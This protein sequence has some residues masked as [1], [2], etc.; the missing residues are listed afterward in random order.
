MHS[1]IQDIRYGL[2]QLRKSPAFT[3]IA[4]LIIATG[5]A[6]NV[7]VFAFRDALFLQSMP[8]QNASGLVRIRTSEN[9]GEGRFAYPEYAYLRDH[10]K[11]LRPLVAHYSTAP[12]YIAANGE[13]EEIIGAAVSSNYFAMLGLRPYIG[14]FFSAEEDSIPDRD[15]VAVIGYGFWQRTYGGDP[16]V[17]GKALTI[18]GRTFSIIGVMPEQF[19]G[20]EIGGN[21]NELWIPTAMIRVG[22]RFCDGFQPSCTILDLIGRLAPGKNASEAQAE[23]AMLRQQLEHKAGGID[24]RLGVLVEPAIGISGDHYFRIFIRLLTGIGAGVLLI[25]CANLGGLLLTRGTARSG[26]LALRQA[27]GATRT[28]IARQLLTESL[29]LALIGGALGVL[30][31][32]WTS[33]WLAA[34][35]S[36]DAEGYRHVFDLRFDTLVLGYSVLVAVV[37]GLLFGLLPCWQANRSDLSCSLKSGGAGQHPSKNRSRTVLIV[38]QVA[39]A[40][41]L[42][43]GAGLLA[44]SAAEIK[45]GRN[46]DLSRVLGLRLRPQLLNYSPA[47]AQA[48]TREVLQRLHNLPGVESVSLAKGI[49]LVWRANEGVR[50]SLPGQ[51]YSSPDD[52]PVIEF[53]PIAP[54]Y[55]GTLGIPFVA[56][57]DLADRDTPE[58]IPVAIVNET[59]A[60]KVSKGTL[61]VGRTIVLNEKPYQVVGIVRDAQTHSIAEGPD[62]VAYVAFWQDTSMVDSRL[63]VRMGG[64]PVAG[65]TMIRKAIAMVDPKVPIT[66]MMPLQEQ[67]RARYTDARVASAVVACAAALGL[68]LSAMGLFAVIAYEI[69]R[70]RQ[71]IG[72]RM[73]MGANPEDVTRLF[74]KQSAALILPGIGLGVGLALLTTRLLAS[75]L[76]GVQPF[77]P[78][79]FAAAIATLLVVGVLACYIS[80]RRAAKVDPMVAL[81]YE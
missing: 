67:V 51:T 63:C 36:V 1:S 28:R 32:V 25:V 12:L 34:F 46:M 80:A 17:L 37:G 65:L 3:A 52:G 9:D 5:V 69:S 58:S 31:S 35:Y 20:V 77:D 48:F 70:R 18:N 29:L 78:A 33:R 4:L 45:T 23:L 62:P 73:A 44:H 16:K 22:Y 8:A 24:E 55:F 7:S 10:A 75:W 2:R 59:L 14:R 50:M 54:A 72:I 43:V 19:R 11:T 56:G 6:A 81:R 27:L 76:F 74:L 60:H 42:V 38:A 39:L 66:E 49:G 68:L 30:I 71:E 79:T 41:P 15:A 47:K 61:S 13:M 57:R 26:E 64:S 53:K 21:P 40:L